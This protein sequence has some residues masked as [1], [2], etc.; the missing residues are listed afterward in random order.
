MTALWTR[1]LVL[2]T[3]ASPLAMAQAE[4]TARRLREQAGVPAELVT[5]LPLTTAGDRIQDRALNAAGGKGLFTKEIEEALLERRADI[6]VHSMKDAPTETPAGLVFAAHPPRE[7]VQDAF[8][9]MKAASLRELPPGATV[10][11]ASL[12]RQAQTLRLRPDLKVA[13]LRGN[14][15]TRLKRL[16]EGAADATYLAM[17][18]LNRLGLGHVARGP[19]EGMLPAVAQGA[20]GLQIRAGDSGLAELMRALHCRRTGLEVAAERAFLAALDGSCR[21]PL[22]GL[23][24]VEGE[25][26]RE[27]LRFEGEILTPDGRIRHHVTLE[28]AAS[29]GEAMGRRAGEI[30]KAHGGPDFFAH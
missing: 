28:G 24:R 5:I 20:L 26:G 29:E 25:E 27:R 21:T 11:T 12:R 17:A 18:G 2:A 8:V 7:D 13:L 4:E 1:P 23:A 19:V 15:Q 3:R 6:A 30:L 14:V 22:A 16:E 10:G 9:S